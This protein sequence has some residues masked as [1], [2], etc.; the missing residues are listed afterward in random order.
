MLGTQ[1]VDQLFRSVCLHKDTLWLLE[2]SRFF[3]VHADSYQSLK[4]VNVTTCTCMLQNEYLVLVEVYQSH[5]I[6]QL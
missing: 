6:L 2:G 1:G 3:P 5:I 4:N